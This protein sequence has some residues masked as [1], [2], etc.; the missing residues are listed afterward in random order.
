MQSV[1]SWPRK[2]E[3]EVV[4]VSVEPV[5][6]SGQKRLQTQR[7]LR[8]HEVGDGAR[9]S[10]SRLAGSQEGRRI[11]VWPSSAAKADVLEKI[12][13]KYQVPWKHL[14]IPG[15]GAPSEPEACSGFD[16]QPA[17]LKRV[18]STWFLG[19]ETTIFSTQ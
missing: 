13:A 6:E 11:S 15:A 5:T 16:E 7:P 9:T 18:Q 8:P 2:V 3:R 17:V 4:G 10:S 12:I 19:P 14:L 1:L